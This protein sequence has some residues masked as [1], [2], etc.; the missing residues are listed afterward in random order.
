[1]S[2][3]KLSVRLIAV[4]GGHHTADSDN[5]MQYWQTKFGG[6]VS[7]ITSV[8]G[9]LAFAWSGEPIRPVITQ[10]ETG[11]LDGEL[12][13]A[14]GFVV[15]EINNE[16]ECLYHFV[17]TLAEPDL[18]TVEA[19]EAVE[20]ESALTAVDLVVLTATP[21]ETVTVLA[22][23][24]PL[25]G[26]GT[27]LQGALR[28]TTYHL[29]RFG[30]YAAAHCECTMGN[31]GRHS[32]TLTAKDAIEE[33]RP[34]A[35]LLLGV[36]FGVDRTEQRIGD[37]LVAESIFPYELKRVGKKRN[38]QR[39]SELQCGSVLSERFRTHCKF[40]KLPYGDRTVRVH[41]GQVLSGEKLIDNKNFRDELLEEFPRAIG[42]EM[43]GA[44]GYAAAARG[45]IETIL[46]K[47]ICDWAD[48]HKN[49]RGQPFAANSAVS[50]AKFIF[51]QVDMLG[52][53][54]CHDLGLNRVIETTQGSAEAAI[55]LR[56]LPRVPALASQSSVFGTKIKDELL[57]LAH[58]QLQ[59]HVTLSPAADLYVHRG[60]SESQLFTELD[61]GTNWLSL[62]GE[63]GTGKTTLLVEV[64][65]MLLEGSEARQS[66]PVFI[67]STWVLSA[68]E[69]FNTPLAPI[70]RYFDKR[71]TVPRFLAAIS[72]HLSNV[73]YNPIVLLDT[74]DA[75][76][77][78][79]TGES[80][81]QWLS[82]FSSTSN[83][84]KVITTCRPL[85]ADAFLPRRRRKIKLKDFSVDEARQAISLYVHHF[86]SHLSRAARDE[87]RRIL[88]GYMA[89]PSFEDICR[90]PVTLRMVFEAY[91]E[92]PPTEAINRTRLFKDY[93]DLKVLGRS[94]KQFAAR[95]VRA[96]P[97][98]RQELALAFAL[99][100]AAKRTHRIPE[101][102]AES[103]VLSHS[104]GFDALADL[105]SE[106]V[107]VEEGRS[108]YKTISFFH[109]SLLEHAAARAIHSSTPEHRRKYLQ[110]QL[111][112]L[113]EAHTSPW[114][115]LLEE[116][117]IQGQR[118]EEGE[119]ITK[120]IM[121]RLLES[122]KPGS[123]ATAARIW[124]HLPQ[125][126]GKTFDVRSLSSNR[127]SRFV[128][129]ENLHNA[130]PERV[131]ELLDDFA[132]PAWLSPEAGQ[133]LAALD[134]WVRV[135]PFAPDP[136][137]AQFERLGVESFILHDP[138][139]T[140]PQRGQYIGKLCRY[141]AVFLGIEDSYAVTNLER[142]YDFLSASSADAR[143]RATLVKEVSA[144][145]RVSEQASQLLFKWLE[146]SEVRAG[147]RSLIELRD[148]LAQALGACEV[149]PSRRQYEAELLQLSR[150]GTTDSSEPRLR[151]FSLWRHRVLSGVC[152]LQSDVWPLFS[153]TDQLAVLADLTE[154]VIGPLAKET[155]EPLFELLVTAAR[156]LSGQAR[157]A[158]DQRRY[159]FILD[160]LVH[161]LEQPGTVQVVL[162]AT[163]IGGS[164]LDSLSSI[165]M[166]VLAKCIPFLSD[167]DANYADALIRKLGTPLDL[168]ENLPSSSVQC[169]RLAEQLV[170][171]LIERALPKEEAP[172]FAAQLS[173][174]AGTFS[175]NLYGRAQSWLLS[176]IRA[177]SQ[178]TRR[179]A[180]R[181]LADVLKARTDTKIDPAIAHEML[182][183]WQGR[184]RDADAV[185]FGVFLTTLLD[186]W[187]PTPDVGEELRNVALSQILARDSLA[188][189][190]TRTSAYSLLK[191][192]AAI[193]PS[194]VAIDADK[195]LSA[196]EKPT[197]TTRKITAE[198]VRGLGEL[199]FVLGE[200][201]PTEA[202]ARAIRL[203]KIREATPP[204]RKGWDTLV[205]V[206]S[207]TIR[208]S[209]RV[210]ETT[211]QLIEQFQQ[212]PDPIQAEVVRCAMEEDSDE[213][214]NAFERLQHSNRASQIFSAWAHIRSTRALASASLRED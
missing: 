69:L 36:A 178:A 5:L 160:A 52:S 53:L 169:L 57:Q 29:G 158:F 70:A 194:Q 168:L 145:I 177:P 14:L 30:R 67:D 81:V 101:G 120:A 24:T 183:Q 127:L 140:N 209:L 105:L 181:A 212:L 166:R 157:T 4:E 44:G 12:A 95:P 88:D 155:Y 100:M 56:P 143:L 172:R 9:H 38:V 97:A 196:F 213:V 7:N 87:A 112:P 62:E 31:V 54:S 206:L 55:P 17:P 202:W 153:K 94:G 11:T 179:A 170:G 130:M 27:L 10:A 189:K 35:L 149:T 64:L 165:E 108:P 103:V 148:A 3:I 163:G 20:L 89:R 142:I 99:T 114:F 85:E 119:R 102:S 132:E 162:G 210:Q 32:A 150:Q 76:L 204:G 93:W 146:T 135:A 214:F 77:I 43:E 176:A 203:A 138:S 91:P 115:A 156:D 40:W 110:L 147:T 33:V 159:E 106:G 200:D 116:L 128:C 15:L 144:R 185:W 131:P 45:N 16:R 211:H 18:P 208:R 164:A 65:R 66:V 201:K 167:Q 187:R 84:A 48:G 136:V 22:A 171:V 139:L 47:G 118:Y 126:A 61:A 2:N 125:Q 186:F 133:R 191:R 151:V 42:G 175:P 109:Q 46:V 83:Q 129:L 6:R 198:D 121:D 73:G 21:I 90:R 37:V 63:S 98:E 123:V 134:A 72:H 192:L 182:A 58:S 174:F 190:E 205:A 60:D 180:L 68:E 26:R 39:G 50:L 104:K 188:W 41:Q 80:V 96:T 154:I 199:V 23:M 1:L 82:D 173:R 71:L 25:P 161:Y 49:D 59:A 195:I 75:A 19:V 86:Y 193:T 124:C 8:P 28:T 117:A 34:K 152:S 92:R 207:G 141:F 111:D 197:S 137:R 74:L 122:G 107:I 113:S 78:S 184:K 51:S 13:A 79:Q